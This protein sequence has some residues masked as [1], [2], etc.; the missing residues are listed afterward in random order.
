MDNHFL[1]LY[2]SPSNSSLAN[3]DR[4]A[5]DAAQILMECLETLS[6]LKKNSAPV[7]PVKKAK[8]ACLMICVERA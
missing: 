4:T 8:N 7:K 1:G 3:R 2:A 6:V 5:M